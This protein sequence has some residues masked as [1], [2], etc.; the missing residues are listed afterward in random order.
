[1]AARECARLQSMDELE[2]LPDGIAAFKALGNAVN[3]TVVGKILANLLRLR[4]EKRNGVPA[5]R[6]LVNAL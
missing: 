3:V 6:H 4:P 2:H 5:V 1:M